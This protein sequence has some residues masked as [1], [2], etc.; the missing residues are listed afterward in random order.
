MPMPTRTFR[1]NGGDS[2]AKDIRDAEKVQ[3]RS[4]STSSHRVDTLVSYRYVVLV[5]SS[6]ISIFWRGVL[7]LKCYAVATA[8]LP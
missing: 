4:F 2:D 7:P 8:C 6:S 3:L 5:L 1:W